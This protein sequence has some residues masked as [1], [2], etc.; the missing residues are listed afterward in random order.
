MLLDSGTT[1]SGILRSEDQGHAVLVDKDGKEIVVDLSTVE[2]KLQ[3]QSAMPEG[4]AKQMTQRDLR[5]LVEFLSGLH[6]PPEADRPAPPLVGG[7]G[8]ESNET[9]AG[10]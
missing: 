9:N 10:E 7:H 6:T 2:D 3:G 4:L 5:D 8:G 1:V